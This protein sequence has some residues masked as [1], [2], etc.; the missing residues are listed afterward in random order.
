MAGG[1]TT[2]RQWVEILESVDPELREPEVEYEFSN[3]RKFKR[4]G[5][6]VL[7]AE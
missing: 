7:R 6:G 3:G 4:D 1:E 5:N 2:T